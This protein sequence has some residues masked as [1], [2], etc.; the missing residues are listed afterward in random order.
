MK[1]LWFSWKDKK[2]PSAGGAEVVSDAILSRLAKDGHKVTLLTAGYTGAT[3]KD[4]I[5]GYQVIRVGGRL[6]VYWHAFRYYQKH[7]K[8]QH[9]FV[10][11]E[12]NTIPFFTP[13]YTKG[14]RVLFFH[15]LA[16]EIWFYQMFFPASFVGYAVEPLYLCLL[17]KERVITISESTKRDLVRYGFKKENI[18]IISVGI[19]IEPV[20]SLDGIKKS[21]VPTILSLGAVRP[22]KRTL[23]IAKTFGILKEHIP[24]ARLIIAG[25][26]AGKYGEKV[27][28]EIAKNKYKDDIQVLGRVTSEEKIHLMQEA[29]VLT[30]TSLK[31]GWGLIV[32]EANSQGTPAVVYNIDGLRDSVRDG[33]TGLCAKENTP[34]GLAESIVKI[35]GDND[36]YEKM[37]QNAWELSKKHTFENQYEDFLNV[38]Q[39]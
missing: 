3:N 34:K 16:R 4:T 31:E 6:S 8:G 24:N 18:S 21:S 30:V 13:W 9:D 22:M 26:M 20:E 23:E 29:H 28:Q 14:K 32:T 25:D 12:I 27:L 1:I 19:D 39:K 5:N 38:I 7:L 36:A 11:E 17:S 2:H 35:L 10:I 33:E 15:Q 37:R